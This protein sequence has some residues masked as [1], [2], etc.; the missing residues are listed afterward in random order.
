MPQNETR[1]VRLRVRA[2]FLAEFE[3]DRGGLD[4]EVYLSEI[5][6]SIAAERRCSRIPKE[7]R[8]IKRAVRNKQLTPENTQRILFLHSEGLATDVIA[9]RMGY[10]I[11]AIQRALPS[12]SRRK[13]TS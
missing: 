1:E 3:R 9:A 8:V 12:T 2:I 6:E 11:T 10:S 7:K 13:V 4:I 5:I